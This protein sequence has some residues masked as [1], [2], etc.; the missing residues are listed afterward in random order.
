[1]K[2][3]VSLYLAIVLLIFIFGIAWFTFSM[4]NQE[5]VQI[6]T[7]TINRDCAPWDGSAFTV[8][9]PIEGSIIYISIYQSP[10]IKHQTTFSFPD[11]T[12]SIG[13]AILVTA[14]SSSEQ[15]TGKVSFSPVEQGSPVEGMFELVTETGGHFKGK[16]IANWGN[17]II[18]CGRFVCFRCSQRRGRR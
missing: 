9:I 2:F 5:P 1:M 17:E 15:L 14:V 13:N 6:F 11:E 7:A 10:E 4:R 12:L 16:F 8:S 18:Y 3:R